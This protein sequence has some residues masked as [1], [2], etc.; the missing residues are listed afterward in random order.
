MIHTVR[1]RPTGLSEEL[2]DE[3]PKAISALQTA[4][5]DPYDRLSGYDKMECETR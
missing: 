4:G 2:L 5:Y 1:R 3:M